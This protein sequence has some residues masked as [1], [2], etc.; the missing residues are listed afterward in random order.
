VFGAPFFRRFLRWDLGLPSPTPP[1]SIQGTT[2]R[3]RRFFPFSF[4]ALQDL[5][6]TRVLLLYTVAAVDCWRRGSSSPCLCSPPLSEYRYMH[7]LLDFFLRLRVQSEPLTQPVLL[8]LFFFLQTPLPPGPFSPP[9]G[10]AYVGFKGSFSSYFFS[11]HLF[12][13]KSFQRIPF[14]F[15]H[16]APTACLDPF[17]LLEVVTGPFA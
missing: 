11:Q 14:F 1:H 6:V 12:V 4:S 13:S 9:Q 2:S 5:V 16:P 8:N 17:F 3:S 10:P 15:C 7:L